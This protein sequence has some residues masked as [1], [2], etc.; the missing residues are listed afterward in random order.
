MASLDKRVTAVENA[1]IELAN[2]V[3][4]IKKMGYV[5]VTSPFL[6]E[7]LRHVWK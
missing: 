4:W 1:I 7:M 3:K 2:D 6:M 5:V